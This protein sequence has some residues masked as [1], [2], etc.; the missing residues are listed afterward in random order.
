MSDWLTIDWRQLGQVKAEPPVPHCCIQALR[1]RGSVSGPRSMIRL[2]QIAHCAWQPYLTQAMW[3]A[4]PHGSCFA[5]CMPSMQIEHD[6]P[7]LGTLGNAVCNLQHAA[8]MSRRDAPTVVCTLCTSTTLER[9]QANCFSYLRVH[10]QY[11]QYDCRRRPS[12]FTT[13]RMS[14]SRIASTT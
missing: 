8:A 13:A 7:G 14:K 11:I 2:R 12:A 1:P 3:N 5:V 4:C 10:A 6:S 9:D